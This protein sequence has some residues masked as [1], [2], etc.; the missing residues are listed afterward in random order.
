VAE[1]GRPDFET[2][3]AI[4]QSKAQMRGMT[5]PD[6]CASYIA[7]KVDSNI[8]DLEG[9]INQLQGLLMVVGGEPKVT[10]ELAREA[11]G[12]QERSNGSARPSVQEIIDAVSGYYGVKLTD[13]LSKRRHKSIALPRQIGMWLARKHTRHSLEEIGGYFGGR[14]HTT[15]MHAIKSINTKC[16]ID[17]GVEHDVNQLDGQFQNRPGR[18]MEPS[19]SSAT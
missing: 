4:I 1:V 9:M 7:S 12:E 11:V 2:R 10:M 18:S 16:R 3:V 8:R 5:M 14:D 15:V 6:D 13:L 17:P 19:V